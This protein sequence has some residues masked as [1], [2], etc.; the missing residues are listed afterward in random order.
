MNQELWW[1]VEEIFHSALGRAPES[2][3]AF[4]DA[5]CGGDPE[6]R[7]E[8]QSLLLREEKVGS[9]LEAPALQSPFNAES[10]IGLQFGPYRIVSALGA[11]GMGEVY[12]SHDTKL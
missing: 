5:A 2:R 4:L 3:S 1:R 6:L 7:R 9:F 8:V 10:V 11:G 12:R